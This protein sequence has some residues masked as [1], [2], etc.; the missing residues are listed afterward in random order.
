MP[1]R[2]APAL[3]VAALLFSACSGASTAPLK[4]TGACSCTADACTC[5]SSA[6]CSLGPA[7]TDGSIGPPPSNVSFG[8][9]AKNDCNVNCGTSCTTSC[10]GQSQCGGTCGSACTT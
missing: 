3:L 2:T 8:C 10:A 9:T 7:G 6:T 5:S 1:M 4:C